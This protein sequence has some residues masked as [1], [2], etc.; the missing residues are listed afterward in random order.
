MP[1]LIGQQVTDVLLQAGEL[2]KLKVV[3]NILRA[4]KNRSGE[5]VRSIRPEAKLDTLIVWGRENFHNM[6]TGVSPEEMK[7]SISSLSYLKVRSNI[8]SW[9]KYLP[10]EFATIKERFM[11][12]SNVVRNIGEK[13]SLLFQSGGRTDIYSNEEEWLLK[14]ISDKVGQIIVNTKIL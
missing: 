7:N 9:S 13:G 12:A 5:T 1:N 11:F 10:L 14:D 3:S 4:K 2:Y 8:A 6:E